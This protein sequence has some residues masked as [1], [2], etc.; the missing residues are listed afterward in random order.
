MTGIKKA[1]KVFT[2]RDLKPTTT[3]G[4][5]LCSQYFMKTENPPWETDKFPPDLQDNFVTLLSAK[6]LSK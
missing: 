2:E 3:E 1:L 4:W 5:A 6:N